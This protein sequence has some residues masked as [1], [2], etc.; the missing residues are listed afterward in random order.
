M[1]SASSL[2]KKLKKKDWYPKIQKSYIDHNE[3][4]VIVDKSELVFLLKKLRDDKDLRFLM[5]VSICGVDY[6]ER[7][8]R[9]EV[10]YQLLSVEENARIRVKVLATD[11]CF[12][13]SVISVYPNANWYEREIWDMYGIKF[14]SHPDLRRILT[15]YGFEGHPLRKDFPLTGNIEVGYDIDDQKVKYSEVHLDQEYRN[16]D[17]L[18]PWSGT[19]YVLPGDEKVKK[20]DK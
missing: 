14:E 17:Y 15:D 8:P 10:V 19:E 9:F 3:L 7:S 18:S 11:E 2:L 1:E 16:F 5:L 4:N 20:N 12:V 6:L 13:P